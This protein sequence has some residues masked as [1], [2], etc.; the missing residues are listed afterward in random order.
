MK[1]DRLSEGDR[2]AR[3]KRAELASGIGAGA[4]GIGLGTLFASYLRNVGAM[5]VF[6]G[7]AVHAIGMWDKHRTEVA[8]RGAPASTRTLIRQLADALAR[9][10]E[11]R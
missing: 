1:I 3:V 8:A 4:L 7:V 11:L 9:T 6:A 5:L 10:S 2:R